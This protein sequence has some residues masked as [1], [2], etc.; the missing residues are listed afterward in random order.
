LTPDGLLDTPIQ[1]AAGLATWTDS[2][3][4]TP[5]SQLAR[6]EQAAESANTPLILGS[7]HPLSKQARE[8]QQ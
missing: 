4:N 5:G 3:F 6:Q 8:N 1:D 2:I 7:D